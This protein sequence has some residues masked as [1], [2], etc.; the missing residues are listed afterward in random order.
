MG[1]LKGDS[2]S[3]VV[4]I[5]D[6]RKSTKALDGGRAV[7]VGQRDR[8]PACLPACRPCHLVSLRL[9]LL[10][11]CGSDTKTSTVVVDGKV[12]FVGG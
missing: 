7:G 6:S 5:R 8:L 2:G 10:L 9:V 3:V 11:I 4:E 12:S 1:L